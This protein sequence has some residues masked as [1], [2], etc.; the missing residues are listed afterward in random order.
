MNILILNWRDS[1][2]PDSGGAERVTQKYASYWVNLGHRV[3]WISNLFQGGSAT[4]EI[5]GIKIIR[6]GPRLDIG[7]ISTLVKYP[8]FLYNVISRVAIVSNLYHIDLIVDE[9]HGLPFFTP[10][11]Y[12]G[13]KVLLTCEVAGPIW[14]KMFRYPLNVI[15]RNLEKAVYYLYRKD[16]IWT[17]SENTTKDI[18]NITSNQH[19]SI[20]PLGIDAPKSV[21]LS[22]Y[23]FPTAVFLGR[24]VKMKGLETAIDAAIEVQRKL[25][26]FKLFIIGSGDPKYTRSLKSSSAV[27]FLGQLSEIDKYNYLSRSHYLWHP[28]YKEGFGLTVIEAGLVGTPTIGRSGSSLDEIIIN[29]KTGFLFNH[30]SELAEIFIDN[31]SKKDYPDICKACT[32]LCK[33]Y[34]WSNQLPQSKSITGIS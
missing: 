13:R 34:L 3:I 19:V 27:V 9:I 32:S 8:L 7:R 17:I 1:A 22:K 6:L 11:F 28:S 33:K 29:N 30:D 24:L 2:N 4:E 26:T 12:R 10:L 5:R 15:G 14:D 21:N 31:Y 23:T 16:E 25:P 20:L 18:K